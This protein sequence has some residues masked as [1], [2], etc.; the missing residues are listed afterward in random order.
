M[1]KKTCFCI[2]LYFIVTCVLLAVALAL[3]IYFL[4]PRSPDVEYIRTETRDVTFDPGPP[5]FLVD[6][7]VF[8][9]ATNPNYIDISL[10][11]LLLDIYYENE[12]V[13]DVDE[14][15]INIPSRDTT[16]LEIDGTM[17]SS[18]GLRD[19]TTLSM[20]QDCQTQGFVTFTFEGNA[21]VDVIATGITVDLPQFSSDIEC[22]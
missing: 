14:D 8:L 10:N 19:S 22:N 17:D 1:E 2:T 5:S 18:A 3:L 4:F 20:I 21:T 6:F 13:G 12:D 11:R 7:T 9:N 16:I 15:D